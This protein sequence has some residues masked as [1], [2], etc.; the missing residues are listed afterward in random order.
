M[1]TTSEPEQQPKLKQTAAP[2]AVSGAAED[3]SEA[4]EAAVA[5]NAGEHVRTVRVFGDRYRCNWWVQE[6]SV[7]PIFLKAGR[8]V[9]SKFFRATRIDDKLLLD[10]LSSRAPAS[11]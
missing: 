8:I 11:L 6:K 3:L 9:R 2:L 7:G 4:I 10:D 1:E 5:K